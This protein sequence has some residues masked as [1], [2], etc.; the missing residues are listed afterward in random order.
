FELLKKARVALAEGNERTKHTTPALL[1]QSLKL[2]R[3]FKR[4]EHLSS[5]DYATQSS[6]LYKFMHTSL[7]SLYTRVSTPGVPDLVLRLFVS[8]GQVAAQCENEDIA[9][10]YF[11]QA[12]T[13]YE[14]SI[15]DSRSQFQAI[16]IIAGALSNC[17]E[18]FGRENYDTL[19]TKAALHGSKLLKKPDQCR[20]VYLASHLWWGVE[21]AEREEG[22]GKE[23]Y[24]DGK[25]VLECLQRALRVADACMDTAVSVE[26][27]VEILNRYVYYFDQEND[28]VT[29]K[30]LNGLVELIHSNLATGAG[31]GVAGLD[32]P[33]RHFERTL[34]YI[35]SR[36][37]EGVE[38]KAK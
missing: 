31:E 6:Q 33:K 15:S 12:F 24:R 22:Q 26:L 34:A 2:A 16:C 35:E 19:I 20:A 7:S 5:D 27:F 1:T 4:R 37:Y 9:Y 21:K 25:R 11:A 17:G 3:N 23:P 30:Y 32:N 14:E 10:E 36:G 28:A 8:C 18:R 13:V 29:T 38:I